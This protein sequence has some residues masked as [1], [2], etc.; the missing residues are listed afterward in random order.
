M[1]VPNSS[2][3][4]Y[5]W[6]R[7]MVALSKLAQATLGSGTWVT[8]LSISPGTGLSIT[9]GPA[10]AFVLAPVEATPYGALPADSNQILKQYLLDGYQTISLAAPTTSGDA[11]NYLLQLTP[12]T[13][14]EGSV[15]LQYFDPANPDVAF[16]G[17]GNSGTSQATQRLNTLSVQLISGSTAP[18]GTQTTPVLTGVIGAVITVTAGQTSIA[19]TDITIA[20][21]SAPLVSQKLPHTA[22]TNANNNF[23]APQSIT[24][25][26]SATGTLSVANGT[27]GDIAGVSTGYNNTGLTVGWNFSAGQGEVDLLLGPQ[28]GTGGLN[29]Y[30]LDSAGNFASTTPIFALT[31][32]GALTLGGTLSVQPGTSGNLAVNYTQ[33]TNGSL[34]PTLGNLT[35]NGTT[36]LGAT[37]VPEAT[38]GSN[39]VPLDQVQSLIPTLF[40]SVNDVT[41]SRAL[42][43]TYTNSTGKPMMVGVS[44]YIDASPNG[45]RGQYG[46]YAYV[47]G[48]Q[49]TSCGYY[50]YSAGGNIPNGL[51]FMVPP[52]AT[53]QVNNASSYGSSVQAWTE[54]Y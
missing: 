37:T 45:Q 7:A 14:D 12:V 50:G 1:E 6:Q 47:N 35:V 39:P 42:G 44:L 52:G 23:S 32:A 43:T 27:A 26:L 20:Q 5:G 54:T 10:Q 9:L 46:A 18:A 31:Q 8:D 15:V 16:G 17:P 11:I 40:S 29:I 34:S 21:G 2:D 53:Y 22:V 19:Q 25:D 3:L 49:V 38:A 4:L 13:E 30:A 51:S 48:A 41:G 24:G 28:S 36:T 33:L